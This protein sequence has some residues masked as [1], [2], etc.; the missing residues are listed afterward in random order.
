M[1]N[2]STFEDVPLPLNVTAKVQWSA[3]RG[4]VAT[5]EDPGEPAGIEIDKVILTIFG[6]EIEVE[7]DSLPLVTIEFI[8]NEIV[9]EI[10]PD[11][12]PNPE[13]YE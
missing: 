1:S 9:G 7:V 6:R 5:R 12:D 10:E 3:Y 2:E 4:T 11:Y 8:E 13:D